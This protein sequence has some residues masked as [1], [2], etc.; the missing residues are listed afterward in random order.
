[1]NDER[2]DETL[3]ARAY[4][5]LHEDSRASRGI[6][7]LIVINLAAVVLE[8]VESLRESAGG[9]FQII[10][11]ISIAVFTIEYAVRLWSC[12]ENPR[13]A[14]GIAGRFRY[15]LTPIALV[16]LAAVLPFYLPL[17]IPADLRFL[18]TLRLLRMIR[19]LKLGRYS[20]AIQLVYRAVRETREQLGVVLIVITILMLMACSAM[21]LFE[22]EAQP[23]QFSSIPATFWWGVMTLTTVGYGDIYPLTVAGR[24]TAAIVAFLGIGLFALPAGI[25]A[26]AFVKLIGNENEPKVCPHCGESIE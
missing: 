10:E 24:I 6:A 9:L 18:R 14:H 26:S 23:E 4:R 17:L 11:V 12:A 19:I 13:F 15:A 16:D 1:M 25:V 5:L 22:N 20:R 8:T 7:V 21:Y 2:T 3:R